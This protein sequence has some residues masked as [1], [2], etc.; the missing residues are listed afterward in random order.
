MERLS[1]HGES[2][3]TTL[4]K[5]F[6][7]SLPALSRHIRVLESARL[8]RRRRHG[9]LHLIQ[10]QT[11]A[12]REAQKWIETYIAGWET[13]FDVLD[14]LLKKEQRKVQKQ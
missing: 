2:Q 1:R 5:P 9:R 13:S 10:A 11:A 7:I 4:V 8:V 12:V 14:Q 3:V 6:H